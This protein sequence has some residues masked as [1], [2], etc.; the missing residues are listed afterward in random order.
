MGEGRFDLAGFCVGIVR[1]DQVLDRGRVQPG[2]ALIGLPSSGLH[3]NGFS[4]VRRTL[5]GG[6]SDDPETRRR[7][8][9]FRPELGRTLGEE[10]LEPTLIYVPAVL[11]A[12]ATGAV[13]A[14]ANITGGG[15][16][17]NVPRALPDGMGAEVWSDR[18]EPQPIFG[19]V[20]ASAG[21]AG[22]DLFGVLNM[23]IGMVLVV[24]D[25]AQDEVLTQLRTAGA[26]PVEIGRA[27]TEPGVTLLVEAAS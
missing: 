15:W 4:L 3:S 1:A 11:A 18:W 21:L 10:L 19:L 17:E 9:E 22:T 24:E 12:L 25:G 20:A 7:L 8:D 2:D 27:T 26:A 14:A 23:G 5:L 6:G 13:R 16:F